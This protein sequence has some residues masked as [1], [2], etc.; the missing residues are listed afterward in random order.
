MAS[1]PFLQPLPSRRADRL[2]AMTTRTRIVFVLAATGVALSSGCYRK[3]VAA[4][5]P[6]ADVTR[7]EK[8]DAPAP[9]T[10]TLGY[11]KY[12]HKSIPGG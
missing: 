7:I 11:P 6:G 10:R 9:E 12:Q 8:P 1:G 2:T 5:G 4:R 3:V